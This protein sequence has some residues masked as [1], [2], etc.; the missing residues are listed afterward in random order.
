M[1]GIPVN[2]GRGVTLRAARAFDGVHVLDGPVAVTVEDG[3]IVSVETGPGAAA[4]PADVDLGDCTLLPGLIDTHTHLVWDASAAPQD[5]VALDAPERTVLRAAAHAMRHLRAGETTVRD[6]GATGALSVPLAQAIADG[7]VPGPRVVPAGRAIAMTGGHGWSLCHEADGPDAVRAAVRSEIKGGAR[8]IKLIASGGVYGEHERPE[9]PQLSR[10]EV[11]VAV[12]EA[13]KAG[14]RVAAHAYSPEVIGMLLDVG[15][16]SIEH[17]SLLDARTAE[18]MREQGVALVPTLCVFDAIHG[19]Y[20]DRPGSP[21]AAKAAEIRS[22]ALAACRVAA[23]NGVTI[24]VGTDSGAPGNP[25]GSVAQE[26]RLMV[27]AGLSPAEALHA[28]TGAAAE[29]VGLAGTAG[30]LAKGR[31]ADL[32][33]YRGDPA[34]EVDAVR[35]VALVML[36]GRVVDDA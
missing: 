12:E 31:P 2:G 23:E 33:A 4:R 29:V 27:E 22:K 11:E 30:R 16:D 7:D 28:A 15:V 21:I 13:H 25:H 24:A 35:D 20:A 10:A 8:A 14:C 34:A 6:L 18:R 36:G 5:R 17:G 32:V 1:T 3:M 19:A 9:E 26:M